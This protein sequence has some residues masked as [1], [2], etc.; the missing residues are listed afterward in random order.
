MSDRVVNCPDCGVAVAE[1]V[2]AEHR[3][4]P[5]CAVQ[6]EALRAVARGMIRCPS[7]ALL[8]MIQE[9]GAPCE[10]LA[11]RA[12]ESYEPLLYVRVDVEWWIPAIAEDIVRFDAPL[13]ARMQALRKLASMPEFQPDRLMIG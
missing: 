11:T 10:Q 3:V 1:P 8:A 2:L 4:T 13:E 5:Y 12:F 9:A 6:C 7:D